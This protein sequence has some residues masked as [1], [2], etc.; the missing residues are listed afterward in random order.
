L[1]ST[2]CT[3]FVAADHSA[4]ANVL[5]IRGSVSAANWAADGKWGVV[6]CP[7]YGGEGSKCNEGYTQVWN[8]CKKQ[9]MDFMTKAQTQNPNYESVVTGHSLGA[10]TAVYA[11]ADVRAKGKEAK[12]VCCS[13]SVDLNLTTH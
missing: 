4:K 11:V 5:A 10:T 3:G 1:G 7:Q 2:G 12:L 8:D 9:A 6:P 13:Y